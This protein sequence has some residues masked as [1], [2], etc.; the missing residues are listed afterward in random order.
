[1]NTVETKITSQQ[2]YL[3]TQPFTIAEVEA[4]VKVMHPDKSSGTD[5]FNSGFYQ[6]YWQDIGMDVSKACVD[7]LSGCH[8]PCGLNMIQLLS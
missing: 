3:L 6:S 4:V 5:G 1:M 7:Y 2:N 8:L